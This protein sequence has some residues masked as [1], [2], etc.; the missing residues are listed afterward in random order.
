[1]SAKLTTALGGIIPRQASGTVVGEWP[2]AHY[3]DGDGSFRVGSR[4]KAKEGKDNTRKR[5][6]LRWVLD[7]QD[8]EEMED[9]MKGRWL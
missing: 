2:A 9:R 6:S 4:W 3:V 7:Q 5:A 1:M 8:G